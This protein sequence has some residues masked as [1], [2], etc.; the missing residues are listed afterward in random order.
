MKLILLVLICFTCRNNS[1]RLVEKNTDR[2]LTTETKT[3]ASV[4]PV[5]LTRDAFDDSG[6]ASSKENVS[7]EQVTPYNRK[8]SP[9]SKTRREEPASS[10]RVTRDSNEKGDTSKKNTTAPHHAPTK[11]KTLVKKPIPKYNNEVDYD[12]DFQMKMNRSPVGVADSGE[13]EDE[14]FNVD[15]YD[16]DINHDEFIGRG[17]PLEPRLKTKVNSNRPSAKHE[18]KSAAHSERKTEGKAHQA[19]V[20]HRPGS[21]KRSAQYIPKKVGEKEDY[22]DDTTTVKNVPEKEKAHEADDEFGDDN[23][24]SKEFEGKGTHSVRTIRSTWKMNPY[25][26]KFGPRGAALKSKVL[27]ILPMFPELPT[28]TDDLIEP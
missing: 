8:T 24:E 4:P 16:F 18:A 7:E 11:Q 25:V 28:I 20:S 2:T 17:K 22:Y 10:D 19:S 26:E 6:T 15:D 12:E 5:R 13:H 1:A 21:N 9:K 14:D 3:T 27:S 23:E